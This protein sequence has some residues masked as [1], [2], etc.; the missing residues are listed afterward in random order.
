[1]PHLSLLEDVIQCVTSFD[2]NV[3]L[4]GPRHY[5]FTSWRRRKGWNQCN[6][7]LYAFKS[8][9]IK[10]QSQS[11]CFSQG[12]MCCLCYS[13]LLPFS[14]ECF[15]IYLPHYVFFHVWN[16]CL[17]VWNSYILCS[18]YCFSYPLKLS[19]KVNIEFIL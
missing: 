9:L 1:M 14:C 2:S 6:F 7:V 17:T 4:G 13:L 12:F 19:S 11:R 10:L 16:K 18:I 5:K 3:N 15:P 8:F